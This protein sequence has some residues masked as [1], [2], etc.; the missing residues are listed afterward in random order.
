MA[1]SKSEQD[2]I[3]TATAKIKSK[4][5]TITFVVREGENDYADYGR[6]LEFEVMLMPIIQ[7]NLDKKFITDIDAIFKSQGWFLSSYSFGNKRW[8]TAPYIPSKVDTLIKRMTERYAANLDYL[9]NVSLVFNIEPNYDVEL[10]SVGEL[11]HITPLKN[12]PKIE[13]DG[14]KPKHQIKIS[15]HPPRVYVALDKESAIDM[16]DMIRDRFPKFSNTK[17]AVLKINSNSVNT[18]WYRDPNYTAGVYT[19][20]KIPPTAITH[21]DTK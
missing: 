4:Y 18:K 16:V 11:Y 12:L 14:L 9:N 5:P 19:Y 20:D 8:N 7:N 1:Q 13:A 15:Q 2:V 17:F 6:M 3:K 10:D 21:I